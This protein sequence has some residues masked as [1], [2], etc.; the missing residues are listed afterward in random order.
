MNHE[1]AKADITVRLLHST[2]PASATALLVLEAVDEIAKLRKALEACASLLG[3]ELGH[4][5]RCEDVRA[6]LA[7]QPPA[8]WLK[9]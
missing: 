1:D 6:L 8:A 4:F 5:R 7:G 3:D 9:A 2:H